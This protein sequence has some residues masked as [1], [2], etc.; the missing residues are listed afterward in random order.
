MNN[1]SKRKVFNKKKK[2]KKNVIFQK[3]SVRIVALSLS[4]KYQRSF[5]VDL[6]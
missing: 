6:V 1:F 3:I 2:K 5:Y 4:L